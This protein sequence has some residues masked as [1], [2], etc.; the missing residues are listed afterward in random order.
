[1]GSGSTSALR[2]PFSSSNPFAFIEFD[3]TWHGLAS[4]ETAGEVERRDV[5]PEHRGQE[6]R[7]PDDYWMIEGVG[8]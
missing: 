3:F 4:R 2:G 8:E 5:V 6:A 1:M 7:E